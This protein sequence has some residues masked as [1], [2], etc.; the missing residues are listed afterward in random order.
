MAIRRT[1]DT[2]TLVMHADLRRDLR[3]DERVVRGSYVAIERLAL[4]D[5]PMPSAELGEPEDVPGLAAWALVEDGLAVASIYTF[6][7]GADCGVYSVGTVPANRRRG[8]ARALV[9]H[10]LAAASVDGAHTRACNQRRWENRCTNPSGSAPPGATR[11]G[12]L[13]RLGDPAH[14]TPGTRRSIN[15]DLGRLAYASNG[16]PTI[17]ASVSV[18]AGVI[19]RRAMRS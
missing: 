12:S 5:E 11:N 19:V 7:H 14:D 17:R 15:T 9:A 16:E 18:R 6:R 2:T 4:T 13:L 8:L 3:S 10:A 1:R